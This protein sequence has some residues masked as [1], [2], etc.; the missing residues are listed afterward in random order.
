MAA[1]PNP[2]PRRVKL[3]AGEAE[4]WTT[5]DY[6][7][8]QNDDFANAINEAQEDVSRGGRESAEILIIIT[9]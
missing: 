9:K 4:A 6:D 3:T 2:K 8:L 7:L 1:E 5:G